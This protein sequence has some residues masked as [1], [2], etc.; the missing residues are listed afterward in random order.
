MIYQSNRQDTGVQRKMVIWLPQTRSWGT[1]WKNK[2]LE[3]QSS[4]KCYQ[5]IIDVAH[6]DEI[7]E[8]IGTKLKEWSTG[9]REQTRYLSTERQNS[10]TLR[11]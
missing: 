3:E 5:V 6:S 8:Y 4:I 1:H 11:E 9:T 7:L 10:I 2:D